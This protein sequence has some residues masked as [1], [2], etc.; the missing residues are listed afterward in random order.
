MGYGAGAVLGFGAYFAI[1][2]ALS[3]I[4]GFSY[5]SAD[6]AN[7]QPEQKGWALFAA[8]LARALLGEDLRPPASKAA[9]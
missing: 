5:V 3:L 6:A 1:A 4:Y 9:G 7:P 8:A 2:L